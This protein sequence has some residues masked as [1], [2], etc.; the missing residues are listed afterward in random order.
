MTVAIRASRLLLLAVLASLG[1]CGKAPERTEEKRTVMVHIAT[2]APSS[3][4][5]LTGE[6]RA[7][8][9]VELAFRV[10]GKIEARLVDAGSE[11][12]A[13]QVLAR[14]DPQDLKLAASAAAA[15]V[16]AAESEVATA[17]A[18]RE[19][20]AGLLAR[21]FVSQAAFD[22]R[23]HALN[24]A[25][26][27]L[28]QARAQRSISANQADYGSL[29]A[30][31]PG[32]VAAVLADAGQVVGAGQPVLRIARPEEKEVLVAV[33]EG[34]VAALRQAEKITVRLWSAP[35]L[36]IAGKLRELGA[37]ADP[38]TRT[39]PA[40]ISLLEA[41]PQAML[42]MTASVS[43]DAA[44]V[45]TVVVPLAAVGDNGQGPFVWVVEAEKLRRVPVRVGNFRADGAEIVGGLRGGEAVVI[46]GISQLLEG[47]AVVARSAPA[48][49]AQR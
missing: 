40:R 1:A 37:V 7:R 16:A 39:Y 44:P 21:K 47:Q 38:Q 6:V 26:A 11:I 22:T 20:Y 18:E 27:R 9:E 8:H 42:G 31:F 5:Q 30:D 33:P 25:Q 19:R 36:A 46:A 32:V 15:Q 49:A 43:L 35:D 48:P 24:A 29:R 3:G 34:R 23:Q 41:P 13:G 12:R 2:A 10:G 28:E 14:L 45:A 17:G 4:M